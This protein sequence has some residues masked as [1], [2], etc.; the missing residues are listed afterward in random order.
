MRLRTRE[1]H[2]RQLIINYRAAITKRP[3]TRSPRLQRGSLQLARP[4]SSR[5]SHTSLAEATREWRNVFFCTRENWSMCNTADL[6][7]LERVKSFKIPDAC[8]ADKHRKAPLS[9]QF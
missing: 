4:R 8:G 5:V 7:E 9:Q 3:Q 1:M 6:Y 2:N